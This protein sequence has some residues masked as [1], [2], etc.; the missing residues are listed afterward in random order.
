[1]YVC[2]A[3]QASV[4]AVIQGLPKFSQCQKRHFSLLRWH[5]CCSR[6]LRTLDW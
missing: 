5:V 1:M 3:V 6:C 2:E 4:L